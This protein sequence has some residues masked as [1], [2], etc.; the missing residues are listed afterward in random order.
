MLFR[1][2]LQLQQTLPFFLQPEKDW[3]IDLVDLERLFV[4]EKGRVSAMVVNNPSNPCG[5]V[6]SR[7][8]L[9]DLL[10]LAERYH[11]PIISDDIYH[12]MVSCSF[13]LGHL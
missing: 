5:S 11:C 4:E 2:A 3:E 1:C 6:Y 10:D 9:L 8:H 12:D 7:Q 13:S